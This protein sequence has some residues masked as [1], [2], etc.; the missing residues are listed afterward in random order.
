MTKQ[1]F[2]LPPCPK[3]LVS[4]QQEM[5]RP[6]PSLQK[7]TQHLA[8]DMALS[9]EVLKTV[10]SPFYGLRKKVSSIAD[11][12]NMVGF[13]RT[14]S[15]VTAASVR[16]SFPLPASLS[17][18]WDDTMNVAIIGGSLARQLKMDVDMAYL[19]GLFHDCATPLLEVKF[20]GYFSSLREIKNGQL[21]ISLAENSQFDTNH[22]M[23]SSL[24][25]RAWH[26]PEPLIQAI[27]F[28]HNDDLFTLG[29][30]RNTL[31]LIAVNLLADHINDLII[32]N[33]DT[34][35]E[36][37]EQPTRDYLFLTDTHQY[38]SIIDAAIDAVQ[39]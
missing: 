35:Y 25:A 13:A 18:F 22:A 27:R 15:M 9:A 5:N 17:H 1:N 7:I 26:L 19:M 31:D 12:I 8:C 4:I 14:L 24:L 23:L 30:E 16:H 21:D 34:H 36:Q 33:V 37:L 11:A 28:H 38:K 10:N 3:V 2:A 6:N 32:G 20:P 39:H 29:L